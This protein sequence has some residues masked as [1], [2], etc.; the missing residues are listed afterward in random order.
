MKPLTVTS[1]RKL[2]EVTGWPD[3]NCVCATVLEFDRAIGCHVA[4]DDAHLWTIDISDRPDHLRAIR[5]PI[6]QTYGSAVPD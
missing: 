5:N 3:C 1:S 2:L 6:N 4:G